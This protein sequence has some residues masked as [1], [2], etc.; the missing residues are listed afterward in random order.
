[1]EKACFHFSISNLLESSFVQRIDSHLT[2]IMQ[3]FSKNIR[4]L[5]IWLAFFKNWS[6]LTIFKK[7]ETWGFYRN[8]EVELDRESEGELGF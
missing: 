1:M 3:I 2:E 7:F 8:T 5:R 4:Y 6:F